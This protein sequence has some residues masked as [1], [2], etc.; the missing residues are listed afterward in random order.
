MLCVLFTKSTAAILLL[1]LIAL[2]IVSEKIR[3]KLQVG[4]VFGFYLFF[5]LAILF[6]NPLFSFLSKIFPSVFLKISDGQRQRV[7]LARAICQRPKL[8]VLDEPTNNLDAKTV[9]WL[10]NFLMDYP[11]I[12]IVVSHNR[13]FLNKICTNIC[14]NQQIGSQIRFG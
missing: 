10:E 14:V 2:L 4:L 12:V 6:Y 13:H 8:L 11:N 9:R 1:F 7:L 3:G 5:F